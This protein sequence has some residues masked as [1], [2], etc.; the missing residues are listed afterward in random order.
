MIEVEASFILEI[1]FGP[2][3]TPVTCQALDQ[4]N[5]KLKIRFFN[6]FLLQQQFEEDFLNNTLISNQYDYEPDTK[7]SRELINFNLSP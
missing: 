5:W 1:P 4:Y 3:S 6:W 2:G 7:P